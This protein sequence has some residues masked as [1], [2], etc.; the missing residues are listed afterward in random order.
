MK[1]YTDKK[2]K[3][4][5]APIHKS[6]ASYRFRILT[7]DHPK[8]KIIG[9]NVNSVDV[10]LKNKLLTISMRLV[11]EGKEMIDFL[12]EVSHITPDFM[13]DF[14]TESFD[15]MHYSLI[16]SDCE[17]IENNFILDYSS[18]ECVSPKLVIKFTDLKYVCD[19]KDRL[20]GTLGI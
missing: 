9:L 1:K 20:F 7:S 6:L 17:V 10:D 8:S 3:K 13:I 18:N 2:S 15:L 5:C 4:L 16:F 12:K 14:L 11:A 19:D